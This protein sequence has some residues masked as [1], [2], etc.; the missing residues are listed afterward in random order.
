MVVKPP[1]SRSLQRV[2]LYCIR[3]YIDHYR[4]DKSYYS[5]LLTRFTQGRLCS[6]R[7]SKTLF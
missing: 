5:H 7:Q 2:A 4:G 3:F 1:L 6:K